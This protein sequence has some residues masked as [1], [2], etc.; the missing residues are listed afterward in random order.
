MNKLCRQNG[1]FETFLSEV[2][3]NV[4]GKKIHPSKYDTVEANI[5]EYIRKRL[6]V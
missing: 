6:R 4:S 3:R 2:L 5:E 1:D